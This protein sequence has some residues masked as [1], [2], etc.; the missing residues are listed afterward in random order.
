MPLG[1]VR[2]YK[3]GGSTGRSTTYPEVANFDALPDPAEHTNEIYVV[4]TSQG[5]Y[6]ISRKPAG[7]YTSDGAEWIY[8]GDLP[9]NYFDDTVF[10]ISDNADSTKKVMFDLSGVPTA[11]TVTLKV[12]ASGGTIALVESTVSSVGLSLPSSILSVTG[13]PVTSSG[14]LAA[15]L[16]A[17]TKN[18]FFLGPLSGSA[19]APTFRSIANADLLTTL[20][21][22][23]AQLGIGAAAG[24]ISATDLIDAVANSSSQV[25]MQL[26]NSGSGP[27]AFFLV[28]GAGHT[29]QFLQYGNA[30]TG[31]RYGLNKAGMALLEQENV[32]GVSSMGVAS[33]GNVPLFFGTAGSI[34]WYMSS[35][36]NTA[37][38]GSTSPAT[39]LDVG[40]PVKIKNY[41]VATLPSA[42]TV[43][44][45]ALAFV[46]DAT[47]TAITGLGTTVV[48]GGSSKVPVYSDGTNWIIL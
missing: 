22:Q 32:S 31:T 7:L 8:T 30:T 1:A 45:G 40:G 27:I 4:L 21:P 44:F 47:L 41:T 37:I 17:Q 28:N 2:L 34:R 12:P 16:V 19:A 18:T 24:S 46:S 42:S 11:T 10:A 48:G 14:T 33:Q 13:S 23:F 5:V 39:T 43:G 6:F 29:V 35:T 38:G 25:N 36:G 3:A 9:D 20:T 15:S 26:K